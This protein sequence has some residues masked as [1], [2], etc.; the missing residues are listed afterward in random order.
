MQKQQE[1]QLRYMSELAEL[2]LSISNTREGQVILAGD[3]LFQG[4]HLSAARYA[5]E[6]GLAR[7][8]M[9]EIVKGPPTLIITTSAFF[10]SFSFF[11]HFITW[12]KSSMT[13]KLQGQRRTWDPRQLLTLLALFL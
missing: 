1:P 6:G 13:K 4:R 12:S 7:F 8:S 2:G 3:S 5:G 9:S 11:S 10:F